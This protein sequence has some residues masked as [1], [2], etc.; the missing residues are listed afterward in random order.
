MKYIIVSVMAL[1]LLT[2]CFEENS[3]EANATKEITNVITDTFTDKVDEVTDVIKTEV[4]NTVNTVTV[5][6]E[7]EVEVLGVSEAT[8]AK[9]KCGTG[10]CGDSKDTDK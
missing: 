6:P 3:A 5:I 4:T 9:G 10:K 2:G 7:T 8:E 1:F